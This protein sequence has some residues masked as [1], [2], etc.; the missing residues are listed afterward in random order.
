MPKTG[1]SYRAAECCATCCFCHTVVDWED[2][3]LYCQLEVKTDDR[4][5]ERETCEVCTC[6]VC[7]SWERAVDRKDGGT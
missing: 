6:C 2:N 1:P 4:P 7:D 3:T 5:C